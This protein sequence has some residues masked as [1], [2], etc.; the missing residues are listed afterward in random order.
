[1]YTA[2]DPRIGFSAAR[3]RPNFF[4]R[5]CLGIRNI[6]ALAIGEIGRFGALKNPIL[7]VVWV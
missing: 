5:K 6:K 3:K 4:D 7:E 2:R 1:M